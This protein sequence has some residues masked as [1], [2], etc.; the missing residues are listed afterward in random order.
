MNYLPR[1]ITTFSLVLSSLFFPSSCQSRT[2]MAAQYYLS[3]ITGCQNVMLRY[4]YVLY[5]N[6]LIV[7]VEWDEKEHVEANLR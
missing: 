7:I 4:R 1:H 5:L 2:V 3:I 6:A